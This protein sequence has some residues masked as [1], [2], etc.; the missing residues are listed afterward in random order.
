[1]SLTVIVVILVLHKG[2]VGIV[3]VLLQGRA[4]P[5]I[6]NKVRVWSHT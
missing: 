3:D 4:D 1:M 2:H 5:N 6:A